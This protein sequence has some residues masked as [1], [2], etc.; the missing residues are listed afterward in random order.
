[1]ANK[2]YTQR[3][4]AVPTAVACSRMKELYDELYQEGKN[5]VNAWREI[6][7][8]DVPRMG[9]EG[10]DELIYRMLCFRFAREC[11]YE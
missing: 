3:R 10:A 5:L 11:G 8:S 9:K 1:M 2:L 7:I 4:D 6:I